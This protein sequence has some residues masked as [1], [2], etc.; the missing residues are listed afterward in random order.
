MM[1]NSPLS[2]SV[3][4]LKIKPSVSIIFRPLL[5]PLLYP[6]LYIP[7]TKNILLFS[8]YFYP[9]K[10]NLKQKLTVFSHVCVCFDRENTSAALLAQSA[11]KQ[12][13]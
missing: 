13:K 4:K 10:Y 6:K 3:T 9:K 8:G 1:H 7:S 12:Q 11:Q 2:I 5:L